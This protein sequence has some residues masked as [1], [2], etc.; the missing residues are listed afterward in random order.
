MNWL[1]FGT[2][3]FL[4]AVPVIYT[5]SGYLH[6][7]HDFARLAQVGW[8]LCLVLGWAFHRHSHVSER[9]ARAVSPAW[10]VSLYALAAVVAASTWH[11]AYPAVAFRELILFAGLGVSAVIVATGIHSE[12]TFTPLLRLLALGAFCYCSVVLTVLTATVAAGT[13]ADPWTAL[14]GFDNPRFLNHC[15][16]VALPLVAVVSAGDTDARWR[17]LAWCTLFL[18]GMLLFI[19]FGRATIL[20]LFMGLLT[21]WFTFGARGRRYVIRTLPPAL[22]GLLAMWGCYLLWMQP[23]GFSIDTNELVKQH[24]R[25]YL[26]SEALSL[27]WTSP[28]IGVGPM[29]FAHWYNGEA[30]H[31]HNVYVQL[32]AEY[33]APATL[34]ILIAAG[35]WLY[36]V[37]RRLGAV[38]DQHVVMAMGL[39]GA[40]LGVVIDGGFSGNFVMPVPQ[41][42]IA[43]L[44]GLTCAFL[45]LGKVEASVAEVGSVADPARFPTFP[46]RALIAIGMMWLMAHA[47][48]EGTGTVGPELDTAGPVGNPEKRTP[49]FSPRF[50]SNGWF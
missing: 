14:I 31:P 4:W 35:R 26:I 7:A 24:Y 19:T 20:A 46:V 45:R 13:L 42:W 38:A 37:Y 28:W 15:Q 9:G 30:A 17:R 50:W 34:I 12:R 11:S 40:L 32:L 48:V 47:L 22:L 33:G 49:L 18:S 23:A 27:W 3:A 16:T 10:R 2:A 43:F 8:M 6:S 41:M 29:H 39:W 36:R 21:G 5:V 1:V 25:G 44:V